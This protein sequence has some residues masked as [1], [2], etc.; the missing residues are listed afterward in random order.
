MINYEIKYRSGRKPPAGKATL[1]RCEPY[2]RSSEKTT[3]T[4]MHN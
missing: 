3:S 4:W 2:T 1:D